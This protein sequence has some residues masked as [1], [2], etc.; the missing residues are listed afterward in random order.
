M[1]CINLFQVSKIIKRV[2]IFCWF[3]NSSLHSIM[4]KSTH[5]HSI[6]LCEGHNAHALNTCEMIFFQRTT[7]L[8][9]CTSE[10]CPQDR[11]PLRNPLRSGVGSWPLSQ[12][13]GTWPVYR[14]WRRGELKPLKRST[15]RIQLH[16]L[17]IKNYQ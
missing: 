3:P 16:L 12:R 1:L 17:Q 2:R 10:S 11:C 4:S 14:R 15:I 13:W 9:S 6:E 5:W 7:T 8:E